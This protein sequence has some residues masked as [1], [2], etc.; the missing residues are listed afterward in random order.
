MLYFDHERLLKWPADAHEHF[1]PLHAKDLMEFLLQHPGIGQELQSQFRQFSSLI[2]SMQ[3]HLYRLQHAQLLYGYS[4]LDPDLEKMLASVPTN[5]QRENLA[6]QLRTRVMEALKNA[7]YRLLSQQEIEESLRLASQWGVRMRVKFELQDWMDVYARGSA[8]GIQTQRHWRNYFRKRPQEVPVYSR[9]AVIFR[10][11]P[12]HPQKFD[13][14]YVYLRLF[15]NVPRKDID[16]MLPGAGIQMSWLDHSRIVLPSLYTAVITLWRIL[17]N[18]FVLA[19]FGVFKTVGIALLVVF[20]VGFGVKNLFSFRSNMV[21]RYMLNMT[22]NL[23]FQSLDNNAGVLLQLLEEAEQQQSCEA[24][25]AYFVTLMSENQRSSMESINAQCG[26]LLMEATGLVIEFDAARAL[27][28]LER[29]GVARRSGDQ[30]EAIPLPE[31]ILRLDALW[32]SWFS[33]G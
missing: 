18:V 14:R 32:D 6:S 24:I 7:N 20:A 5:S 8:I 12:N 10:P 21:R 4:P 28:T 13:S 25:L 1:V 30:W 19:L 29:F 22:Q 33:G 3:H 23:Y 15:K 2:L 17:R 11:K 31:A 27:D 26:L 9:L 16:M